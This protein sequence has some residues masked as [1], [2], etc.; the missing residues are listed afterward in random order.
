MIAMSADYDVK[1]DVVDGVKLNSYYL[2]EDAE[3][4]ARVARRWTRR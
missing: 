3:A 4:G 2:K 1:S